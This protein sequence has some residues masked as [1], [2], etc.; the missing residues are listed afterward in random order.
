MRVDGNVGFPW[1][2][3]LSA[4]RQGI[5]PEDDRGS[6]LTVCACRTFTLVISY[7]LDHK[8]EV[9]EY[10]RQQELEA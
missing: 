6:A 5:T 9:E 8:E 7:Y 10:L 2:G 3:S 1:N 4:T